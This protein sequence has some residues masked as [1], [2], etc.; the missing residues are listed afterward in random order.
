[1]T[2]SPTILNSSWLIFKTT[3]CKK[4]LVD[5]GAPFAAV[6]SGWLVIEGHL[7]RG[8]H[9]MEVASDAVISWESNSENS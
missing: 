2:Q 9:Y 8:F 3:E 1:M 5:V 6:M 4:L 7:K